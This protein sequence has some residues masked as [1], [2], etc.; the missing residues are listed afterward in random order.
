MAHLYRDISTALPSSATNQLR[1]ITSRVVV[2]IGLVMSATA[3][4]QVL[5]SQP[6]T[7]KMKLRNFALSM[8]QH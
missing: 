3:Q 2:V 1:R 6:S 5:R 4:N 8:E 7:I